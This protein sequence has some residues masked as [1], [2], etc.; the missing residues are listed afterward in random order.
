[1]MGTGARFEPDQAGRQAAEER[2]HLTSPKG[3]GDDDTARRIDGV[4]LKNA[5]GQIDADRGNLLHGRCSC[6]DV[7]DDNHP[8][9]QMPT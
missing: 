7:F 6:D 5:L 9:T 8:G 4:N 2:L 3:L 1:M